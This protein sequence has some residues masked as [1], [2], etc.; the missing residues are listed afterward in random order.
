MKVEKNINESIKIEKKNECDLKL[1][2][3]DIIIGNENIKIEKKSENGLN[4]AKKKIEKYVIDEI[5]TIEKEYEDG[6]KPTNMKVNLHEN[7]KIEKK[8]E[9]GLNI[10]MVDHEN[11]NIKIEKKNEND[12]LQIINEV[13]IIIIIINDYLI[14]G[15]K[16]LKFEKQK[17]YFIEI[18]ERL[19]KM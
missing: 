3:F 10:D 4:I 9:N 5:I 13:I 6:Q 16:N 11:E 18:E 2:I 15:K 8:S 7:I 14:D 19:K 12:T 17:K 1:K